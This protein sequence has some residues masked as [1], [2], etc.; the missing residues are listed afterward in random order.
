MAF[1]HRT[2]KLSIS[3]TDF[4][5][6]WLEYQQPIVRQLA[7]CVASPNILAALPSELPICHAFQLHN[8]QYW[9]QLYQGYTTRLKQLD[10]HPD[11]LLHFLS[12]LKSTRLG[13]R[14]EHLLWFWLQDHSFHPYQLLGH[15]IQKIDGARTLGELDFVLFNEEI[16][17]VEHWEVALK[18]YLAEADL[19]LT[20][21]YGLNRSDTL[22]RKLLHFT[23]RQFQFEHACEQHIE[24]RFAVFKGQLY[25]PLD[26]QDLNT[27]PTWVN[28][29]RRLGAWGHQIPKQPAFY[30]LQRH[31]WI[32]PEQNASSEAN[33]WWTDGLYHAHQQD[34]MFRSQPLLHLK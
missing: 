17:K 12:Q 9:Q 4:F 29:S 30:R 2:K 6:P 34:F 31:E 10:C 5:E 15:S 24:A 16:K 11:P 25:L 18:Y 14:F 8:N 19:S 13:L 28:T 23:N 22:Q 7:F 32:C 26:I 33:E 20:H 3:P 1:S 27:V 21:W